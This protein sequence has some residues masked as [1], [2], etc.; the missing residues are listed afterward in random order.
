MKFIAAAFCAATLLS[1]QGTP[2]PL[3]SAMKDEV[4]RSKTLEITGLEKPYF[5]EYTVEDVRSYS[6]S[7]TLGAL[8]ATNTSRNRV[9]R[10]RV[11]VGDYSFD[12]SN[13]VL[14]DAG[15]TGGELP[16]DDDYSVLRRNFW[17]LTDRAFKSAVEVITRKRAAMKNTTQQEAL[18]DFWKAPP[19]QKLDPVSPPS[20]S[21]ADWS[22]RLRNIS[23]VFAAYPQVL[24]SGVTFQSTDAMFYLANSEGSALRLP[25]IISI[26]EVRA[27]GQAPD[28]MNVRDSA[29][30]PALHDKALPS[31]AE[32]RKRAEQVAQN[33]KA[34]IAAP[35]AESY[36]GPVLFE[37]VAGA[38]IF[39]EL[40]GPQLTLPRRP[41]GEPGRPAPFMPSEFETRMDYRVLPDFIDVVDD[42]TQKAWN[43]IPLLGYYEFDYEGVA[44]TAVP[45]IEKGRI[46]RF[47]LTRQPVRGQQGTNGHARMPGSFGAN[48]AAITNLFVKASE[49]VKKD[50]LKARLI[51]LVQDRQRP[52][53]LIVRKMD[54]PTTAPQ[55]ELRR[56]FM[57]ASQSGGSA[58][59][60]SAPLLVFRVY[61]DGK[62]ELVRG[63]RFRGLGVRSLRDILAVSDES[64]AFHYM[65]TLAPMSLP[66]GGYV[67]PTSVIAPSILLEDVELERPQEDLP[68]LPI[69]PPPPLSVSAAA[70][71]SR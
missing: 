38:Q 65:N 4:E 68:R 23:M 13:Y 40:L 58:R 20:V 15:S 3:L 32:L 24:S 11:R 44:P 54:F 62:E 49:T 69:A 8:L 19:V 22:T 45:V 21:I 36:S 10:T 55:D 39:A 25:D 48:A 9:P 63:L 59:P 34:L 56:S 14:S 64:F 6:I 71:A 61:P 43:G 47:L 31:E 51:K 41:I 52:Y 12:N 67:A 35:V 2:D 18:A 5:I 37:G 60:V 30:L 29:T 46:K 16:L 26:F 17:L 50:E 57:A 33:V 28:G 27:T 70:P 42:P 7:A 53:G 1:A 66:G